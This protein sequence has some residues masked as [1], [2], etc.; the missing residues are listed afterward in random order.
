MALLSDFDCPSLEKVNVT[1][2]PQQ[3]LVRFEELAGSSAEFLASCDIAVLNLA[4]A[5]GLPTCDGFELPAFLNKLDAWAARVRLETMRHLYRFDP[6]SGEP[7]S[8]FAYGNSLGRFLCYFLLQV[9]QE[10]CGVRYNPERKFQPD[11]C[12]PVDLFIHGILEENA[13]GGTCASMPVVY[14]AVGRRLGYPVKLVEGREH[15]FFRWDDPKGTLIRWPKLGECWIAPDRFNIEGTGEGIGYYPDSHYIQWPR[16]WT[17]ADFSHCRYLRSLSAKEE[18]AVFLVQRGECFWDLQRPDEAFKAYYFARKLAPDDMRYEWLHAK[19]T[20]EYD[21]QAANE[22]ERLLEIN[23]RLRRA[24]KE[25]QRNTVVPTG[26]V[27][28]V[29]FGT[30]IPSGLPAG[31]PIQYVPAEQADPLPAALARRSGQPDPLRGLSGP[32]LV[33]DPLAVM[34]RM[35]EQNRQLMLEQERRKSLRVPHDYLPSSEE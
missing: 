25:R 35:R 26:H 33:E 8:E 20:R 7:P 13:A 27:L 17:E 18:L 29:A 2:A 5:K 15:L 31:T 24:V 16:L 19:R 11:F 22:M 23:E 30:P 21:A 34:E 6:L 10:D 1:N 4:A 12:K 28:R 32:P 14:V 3:A 9:L